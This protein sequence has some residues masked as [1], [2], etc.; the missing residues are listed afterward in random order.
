MK[1]HFCLFL[2]L[3]ITGAIYAQTS[4]D[5]ELSLLIPTR[6]GYY[7]VKHGEPKEIIVTIE[8]RGEKSNIHYQ[9]YNP[10]SIGY[11]N[12]SYRGTIHLDSLGRKIYQES[13]SK[14]KQRLRYTRTKYVYTQN[15]KTI[16]NVTKDDDTLN[17]YKVTFNEFGHPTKIENF[18][19]DGYLESYATATYSIAEGTFLYEVY[20]FNGRRVLKQLKYFNPY[21]IINTNEHGDVSEM[22]WPTSY[23]ESET[24]YTIEYKYD[25][26]GNWTYEKVVMHTPESKKTIK[27]VT[28]KISYKN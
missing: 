25:K 10:Q 17:T 16:L 23:I 26:K 7:K 3:T 15:T 19:P 8:D 21:F 6:Q 14:Y 11:T 12:K 22:Y 24:T 5:T 18:T 20:N 4:I 1:S 27:R 13:Y 28:R 2:L 9:Y